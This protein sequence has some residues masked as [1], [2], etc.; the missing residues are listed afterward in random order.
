MTPA[1]RFVRNYLQSFNKAGN[2]EKVAHENEFLIDFIAF[3]PETIADLQY[4]IEHQQIDDFYNNLTSLKFL[5]EYSDD[6]NRYWYLLRALAGG[7]KRLLEK[8]TV[9]HAMEVY[10]YYHQKYGGRRIFKQDNWFEN[11]RWQFLDRLIDIET[12][13]ELMTFIEDE[14]RELNEYFRVY[15]NELLQFHNEVKDIV[16]SGK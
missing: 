1:E 16:N 5:V 11:K 7:I 3:V 4:N 12:P 2:I 8:E 15:K 13:R 10:L 6:L 14:M 9:Q